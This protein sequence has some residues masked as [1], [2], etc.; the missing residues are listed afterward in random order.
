MSRIPEFNLFFISE[1]DKKHPV[2]VGLLGVVNSRDTEIEKLKEE[3]A[4]LKKHPSKPKLR[5]STISQK[6]ENIRNKKKD[7]SKGSSKERSSKKTIEIHK[8]ICLTPAKIPNGSKLVKKHYYTIQDIEIKPYNT[9]YIRE[10][11]KTPDGQYLR[12][13][14]PST[15]SGHFGA[16][17]KA[18]ILDLHYSYH[19]SQKVLESSFLIL[20]SQSQL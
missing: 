12:A 8:E 15:V 9:K 13:P 1:E 17:L 6:D 14:L 5:P 11:W 20:E 2:V 10:I 16:P 7:I 19:V 3:I 18:Y 4:R